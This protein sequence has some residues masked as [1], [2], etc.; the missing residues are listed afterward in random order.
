[1]ALF[2]FGKKKEE[3]KVPACACNSNCDVMDAEIAEI[4]SN[5]CGGATS[6][7]CCIKV[8][9]SGCKSCHALLEATKEAVKNMGLT[10]VV[11]YVTDM[12]KIM[13]YGVMSMP[14]L[15]VNENVVSMGKVLKAAEV[16]KLLHKLGF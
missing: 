8:L 13:E 16:E 6:G 11:E 12:E 4:T 7:I 3:K 10:I 9:G 2:N 15:V 5:C 14:A 1:M